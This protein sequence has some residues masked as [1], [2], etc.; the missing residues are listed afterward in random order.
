MTSFMP[1]SSPAKGGYGSRSRRAR[2]GDRLPLSFQ[3]D[4]DCRR[5]MQTC[6]INEG[7]HA[8]THEALVRGDGYTGVRTCMPLYPLMLAGL[9]KGF[10]YAPIP[11]LLL[12]AAFGVT[13]T[14]AGYQIGRTLF[15]PVVGL[16]AGFV[17]TLH[18]YLVNLT[19]QIIGTGPSVAFS[20]L[21][22][23]CLLRA[24][25]HSSGPSLCARRTLLRVRNVGTSRFGA[26]HCYPLR[27]H[28]HR[29]GT[30][31]ATRPCRPVER[32]VAHR[33]DGGHVAV[34]DAQLVQVR[35]L[36]PPDRT[37]GI[38]CPEGPHA[39]LQSRPSPLRYG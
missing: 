39:V 19:M 10:G 22:M 12:H 4:A 3:R 16:V 9:L 6:L 27:G 11:L 17:L 31:A 2:R 29:A 28:P 35:Y 25:N 32:S 38:Q 24:W 18:P 13:I 37:W 5:G 34:V 1:R 8:S 14:W 21:G 15:S 20:S 7:S 30:A 36:D 23:V 26:G 33:V